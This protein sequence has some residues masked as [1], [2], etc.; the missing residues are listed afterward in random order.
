[1]TLYNG[2]CIS[3]IADKISFKLRGPAYLFIILSRITRMHVLALLPYLR[4][5]SHLFFSHYQTKNSLGSKRILQSFS[6]FL[7]FDVNL[8]FVGL[9][10]SFFV[11]IFFHFFISTFF[12]NKRNVTLENTSS[13]ANASS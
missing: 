11:N 13:V 7:V 6:K 3:F 4:N 12:Y 1:M 8:W 10:G 2:V 5:R 9:Q